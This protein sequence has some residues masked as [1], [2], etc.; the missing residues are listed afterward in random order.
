MYKE[1]LYNG[2]KG[3]G[4]W[5]MCEKC[6]YGRLVILN[7]A[8]TKDAIKKAEDIVA[9]AEEHHIKRSKSKSK[10][11]NYPISKRR[12]KRKKPAAV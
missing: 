9:V 4:Y 7:G 8:S 12:S 5:E 11:N 6:F 1:C 3:S 2:R 10:K